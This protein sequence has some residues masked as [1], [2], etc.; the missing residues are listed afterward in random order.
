M[1]Q[2]LRVYVS[3]MVMNWKET[4]ENS[5]KKKRKGPGMGSSM[6]GR[7]VKSGGRWRG[8][9]TLV[10][11]GCHVG[12]SSARQRLRRMARHCVTKANNRE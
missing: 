6:H 7:Q 11:M 12:H 8:T 10:T 5:G 4:Y 2:I 3:W 9:R 1:R